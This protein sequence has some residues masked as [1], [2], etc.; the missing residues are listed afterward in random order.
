MAAP[1]YLSNLFINWFKVSEFITFSGR[2]L[3]GLKLSVKNYSSKSGNETLKDARTLKTVRRVYIFVGKKWR[4]IKCKVN[5]P[6][7][8][9]SRF[10][11]L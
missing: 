6:C 5:K 1:M 7:I 3:H 10:C 9:Y 8:S 11:V 4:G 2:L